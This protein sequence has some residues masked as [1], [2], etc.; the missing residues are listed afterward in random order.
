MTPLQLKNLM[1]YLTRRIASLSEEA[2]GILAELLGA[3]KK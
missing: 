1:V 2:R 3:I